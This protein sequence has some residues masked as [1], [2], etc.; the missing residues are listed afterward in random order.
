MADLRELNKNWDEWFR[1][2]NAGITIP[3]PI[4]HKNYKDFKWAR[5]NAPEL[6]W[7]RNTLYSDYRRARKTYLTNMRKIRKRPSKTAK[8]FDSLAMRYSMANT[9][10]EEYGLDPRNFKAKWEHEKKL[11]K[12]RKHGL[13]ALY[14]DNLPTERLDP[15]TGDFVTEHPKGKVKRAINPEKVNEAAQPRPPVTAKARQE[16]A[17]AENSKVKIRSKDHSSKAG[18][19]KIKTTGSVHRVNEKVTT[20]PKTDLETGELFATRREPQDPWPKRKK[21]S[22]LY[23]PKKQPKP[24]TPGHK[25]VPRIRIMTGDVID[26][27]TKNLEKL[28]NPKERLANDF[29]KLWAKG[30]AFAKNPWTQ[31][32]IAF[33]ATTI[34]FNVLSSALNRVLTPEDERALP[35]EYERGYDIIK[36]SLTDFGSPVNL[37]QTVQKTITP[38]V[39]TPRRAVYTTT[40]AV[41]AGNQALAASK[42]AINHTRY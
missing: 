16:I 39:S 40:G 21:T 25:K 14:E 13:K 2:Q 6:I 27:V 38:Y 28:I 11:K 35:S 32:A 34:A 12:M 1:K 23:N 31:R 36:Q 19:S 8:F 42:N 33:G 20:F 7:D 15:A 17:T 10:P 30:R 26:D 22:K 37:S 9:D 24:R 18:Q 3:D 41:L 4:G 5:D 29:K